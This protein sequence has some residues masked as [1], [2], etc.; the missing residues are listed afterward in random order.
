MRNEKIEMRASAPPAQRRSRRAPRDDWS[1][2]A[3]VTILVSL[4]GFSALIALSGP[5]TVLAVAV[6]LLAGIAC[7]L[8]EPKTARPLAI[9]VALCLLVG[10]LR[11]Q[12]DLSDVALVAI[13]LVFCEGMIGVRRRLVAAERAANVDSLTGALTP[14]GFARMLRSELLEAREDGRATALIFIDLDHFKA[15]ND[16]FGHAAGD[17]VLCQLVANLKARLLSEDHIARVG[18]DEFLVFLRY[19]DGCDR[20]DGFEANMLGAVDELPYDLSAS[21]G[22]LILPPANYPDT[23]AIIQSADRLMYEVKHAGRGRIQFGNLGS[24]GADNDSGTASPEG[25]G[26]EMSAG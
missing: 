21:A 16:E 9:A 26:V 15:V 6:I 20:I 8:N 19:A 3:T 2:A 5:T 11:S 18:G 23:D 12:P 14:R 4:A 10:V 17:A 22:G 7:L 24:L 25:V 1:R 13:A